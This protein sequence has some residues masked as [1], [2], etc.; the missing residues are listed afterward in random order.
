[1]KIKVK[2]ANGERWPYDLALWFSNAK[3]TKL[4][5]VWKKSGRSRKMVVREVALR[6]IGNYRNIV[7]LPEG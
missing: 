5:F 3:W 6:T 4:L 7:Y 1:M 2:D